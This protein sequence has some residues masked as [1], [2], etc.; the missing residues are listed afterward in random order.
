MTEPTDM[1]FNPRSWLDFD[2]DAGE[3]APRGRSERPMPS[4][5]VPQVRSRLLAATAA[6]ALILVAGGA[7]AFITRAAPPTAATEL[8]ARA[9]G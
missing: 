6:A 9:P 3:A 1:S 7:A 8:A 4:E 2:D 5:A